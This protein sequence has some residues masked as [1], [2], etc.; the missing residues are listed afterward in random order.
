MK[1][2]RFFSRM[3]FRMYGGRLLYSASGSQDVPPW[4]LLKS[5]SLQ[6]PPKGQ[7]TLQRLQKRGPSGFSL[8]R[9]SVTQTHRHT[10]TQTH[11]HTDTQTHSHTATQ[12]HRH[13]QT[14]AVPSH[15]VTNLPPSLSGSNACLCVCVCVCV[16]VCVC[17]CVRAH[18]CTHA[19]HVCD[20]NY[21]TC[22]HVRARKHTAAEHRR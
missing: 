19:R 17:V 10:D 7:R 16:F 4:T 22:T 2:F 9:E 21:G 5:S 14:Q 18:T 11:R 6:C 13:I 8:A 1:F 15:G 20:A 12:T 3:F